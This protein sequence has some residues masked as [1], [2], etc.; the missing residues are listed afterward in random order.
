MRSLVLYLSW[1]QRT[2]D[3]DVFLMLGSLNSSTATSASAA[4]GAVT[5][6]IFSAADDTE[7]RRYGYKL[8]V[9]TTAR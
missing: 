1:L 2:L 6:D 9:G 5:W 3:G 7:F 4:G 8:D